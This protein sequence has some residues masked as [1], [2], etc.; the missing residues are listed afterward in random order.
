MH[1]AGLV[2]HHGCMALG[3]KMDS[4]RAAACA[5]AKHL[6]RA[7]QRQAATRHRGVV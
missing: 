4:L 3:A 6:C 5:M 7:D 2:A 1:D